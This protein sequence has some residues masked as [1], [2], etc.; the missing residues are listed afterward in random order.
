MQSN[1]SSFHNKFSV[2]VINNYKEEKDDSVQKIS[3]QQGSINF[4]SRS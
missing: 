1:Y 2:E 3:A 4:G